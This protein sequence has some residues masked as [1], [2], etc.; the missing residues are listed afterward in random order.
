MSIFTSP[1]AVVDEKR[2]RPGVRIEDIDKWYGDFN[3]VSGVSIDVSS[4]ELVAI[5]GPSGSGKTTLLS[6]IAGILMPDSGRIVFGE[7]D[8]TEQPLDQRNIGMVFQSYNLFPNKTVRENVEFPLR[9][10]KLGSAETRR[11]AEETLEMVD[12]TAHA[13]KYPSEISG[14]Q[15]QRVAL[16]RA[17]VFSPDLLLMDEPLG[18]LDRALRHTL[19]R[20]FRRVQKDFS[21][22]AIYVTHDQEEAFAIADRLV[23]VRDGQIVAEGP[24]QTVYQ[25]PPDTWVATFLGDANIISV[26]VEA[27]QEGMATVVSRSQRQTWVGRAKPGIDVGETAG[28]I[29][30]PEHLHVGLKPEI[31]SAAGIPARVSDIRFLGAAVRVYLE[32]DYGQLEASVDS[33]AELPRVGEEAHCTWDPEHVYVTNTH[34]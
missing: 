27:V 19:Q 31:A 10:R 33:Y 9:V 5:L 21:I 23:I 4:R 29:I 24:G 26:D 12:L 15:A 28:L 17:L 2:T 22:P 20:E 3:A 18:A 11:R 34:A 6:M 13:D 14:G 7:R 25:S 32:S 1:T 8:V 30:R 16:A